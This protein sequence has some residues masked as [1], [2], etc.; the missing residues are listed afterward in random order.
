VFSA[1]TVTLIR[2]SPD[3]PG[4]RPV[5]WPHSPET[6]TGRNF[7]DVPVASALLVRAYAA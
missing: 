4:S 3:S 6:V 2:T 1:D 7:S 5:L